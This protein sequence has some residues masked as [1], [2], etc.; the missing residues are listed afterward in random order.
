MKPAELWHRYRLA[1]ALLPDGDAAGDLFMRARSDGELIHL[2]NR[3]RRARGLEPAVP[4]AVLPALDGFQ[5]EHA[6]HLYRRGRFRRRSLNGLLVVGPALLLAALAWGRAAWTDG[7]PALA[8]AFGRAPVRT[9]ALREGLRLAVYQALVTPGE[10]TLWWEV[11]G[12]G[13]PAYE[14]S[15]VLELPGM[16]GAV[17]PDAT[18]RTPVR[19]NRVVARSTY[20]LFVT[21]AESARLRYSGQDQPVEWV[22]ELPLEGEREAA[23]IPLQREVAAGRY[24]IRLESVAVS[25]TYTKVRYR[26]ATPPGGIAAEPGEIRV[27][28]HR[29]HAKPPLAPQA[30]SDLREAVY[31]PIPGGAAR[32]VLHFSPPMER[33]GPIVYDLPAPR[34]LSDLTWLGDRAQA[35]Y[36]PDPGLLPLIVPGKMPYFTDREGRRYETQEIP[37]QGWGGMV[38]YS[39]VVLN[40]PAEAEFVSLTVPEAMRPYPVAPVTVVLTAR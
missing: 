35:L 36:Q 39:L 40:P 18:E 4:P 3:W 30:D 13:A 24:P 38:K 23:V 27:G 28:G 29:L 32:F 14:I 2:A 11:T 21:T 26:S 9:V 16:E 1:L 15:P 20:S 33:M 12:P 22:L 10:V 34:A 19:Q 6:L 17:E 7:G 25:P 37:P 31:E 8:P 5:E